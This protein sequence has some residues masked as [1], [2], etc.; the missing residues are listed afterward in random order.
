MIETP[1][2]QKHDELNTPE[3]LKP[4]RGFKGIGAHSKTAIKVGKA[5]DDKVIMWT[6]KWG[7]TTERVL[8]RLLGIKYRP[9]TRLIQKGILKKVETPPKTET[10]YVLTA[11]AAERAIELYEDGVLSY[12]Y[13]RSKIPESNLNHEEMSQFLTLFNRYSEDDRYLAVREFNDGKKGAVPDFIIIKSEGDDDVLEWHETELNP[14]KGN[15]LVFKIQERFDSF[16]SG[17]FDLLI[18]H[19]SNQRVLESY[20]NKMQEDLLPRVIRDRETGKY[21]VDKNQIGFDPKDLFKKSIFLLIADEKE[22]D[23]EKQL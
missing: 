4:G 9:A 3:K 11:P 15:D 7:W 16:R 13:L 6:F 17:K 5:N 23:F 19:F 22:N 20:R 18:W 21:Y 8:M 2:N 14:K 1:G 12:P 10:A